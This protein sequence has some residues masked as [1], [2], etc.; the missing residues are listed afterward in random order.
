MKERM[1]VLENGKA[2]YGKGFGADITK[3]AE[4]VFNTS[5]V[6]YQEI[7]SDPSYFG[8]MVVM[9]YPLI[10]NYGIT[11]DDNESRGLFAAGLIVRENN[12]LPSNFRFTKTLSQVMAENNVPGI[13]GVDTRELIG[14]I[15]DNGLMRAMITDAGRDINK[16]VEELK[17]TVLTRKQVKE[18]TCQ[19]TWYSR[20]RNPLYTVVAV[21]CGIKLSTVRE[22]NRHGCN[23]AVVPF[24]TTPE[25]IRFHKPDG[26]LIGGG[27][28]NPEDVPEAVGLIKTLKGEIPILGICLGYQLIGLSYGAKIVKMKTGHRGTNQPVKDLAAGRVEITA[29]NHTYSVDGES[30]K[31]TGLAV[32]HVNLINGEPEGVIDEA[33]SVIGVQFYPESA[34]DKDGGNIFTV[35]TETMKRKGGTRNAKENRY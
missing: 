15:R 30:L 26:I 5:M 33:Q 12:D 17:N 8:Q 27:P 14:I 11:D 34:E 24:N 29:Q 13:S 25:Q 35:F 16:C 21:D 7:I 18:V 19:K 3:V 20:T 10:G 1:L 6:G 23:V 2:Y 31:G 32:T 22:L 9:S 28:G 4:I